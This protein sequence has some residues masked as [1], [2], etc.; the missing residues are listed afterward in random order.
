MGN[1]WQKNSLLE[2]TQTIMKVHFRT[3][4]AFKISAIKPRAKARKP[5]LYIFKTQETFFKPL[6]LVIKKQMLKQ[7]LLPK[8]QK[9]IEATA[10]YIFPCQQT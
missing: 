6:A 3:G 9:I 5:K 10:E 8:T 7:H 4:L 1:T 2:H